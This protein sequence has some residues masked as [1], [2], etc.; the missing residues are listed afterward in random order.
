MSEM[1]QESRRRSQR[2]PKRRALTVL[3]AEPSTRVKLAIQGMSK[4][5]DEGNTEAFL[6]NWRM[7]GDRRRMPRG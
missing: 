7:L 5:L 3:P 6:A 4:A 1:A 2:S